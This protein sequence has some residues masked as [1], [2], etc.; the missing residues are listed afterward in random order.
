MQYEARH[1]PEG[2]WIVSRRGE[3]LARFDTRELAMADIARRLGDEADEDPATSA[4]L[5][6]HFK[7]GEQ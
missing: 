1:S 2:A 3:E 5:E 4:K 6:I 7:P